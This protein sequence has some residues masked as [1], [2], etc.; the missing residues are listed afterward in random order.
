MFTIDDL[1]DRLGGYLPLDEIQ[2]VK[3]AFYYAEQAHDGQCR[4]SGEPYVTHPLAVSNILAN[5]H[6]DHQSLM[7]AML[8]DV[9]E[10]TGISKSALAGQF[11]E[12]VA[13]LVDGVSKLTQITFED[14]AVAQAENF[15]KMVMAMSQDIRVIIVKLADRL[16][17]MRTLGPLRPDK[18]RRIARETLEIYAR[19]AGRLG[20]NTIRVELEDLSFQAI[21]PMRAERIKR[22]V[23]RARGNRRTMI[24]Q[25][26]T[27][28]FVR[29]RGRRG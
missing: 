17:N 12:A 5:M 8:H 23:S 9:I 29:P 15:Q 13:E 4:R 10:D 7:A 25:V 14:K 16:H 26:L 2:Q 6:M 1:A 22:A 19:I 20:I 21:Y 27:F 24:R 3:R 11:G 18:K 28:P